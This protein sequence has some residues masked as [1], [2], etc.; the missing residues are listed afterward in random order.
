MV[1]RSLRWQVWGPQKEKAP[2]GA[3]FR[4]NGCPYEAYSDEGWIEV[5]PLQ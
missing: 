5:E 4:A 1:A 3:W 2:Q